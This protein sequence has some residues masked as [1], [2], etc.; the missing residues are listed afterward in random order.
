VLNILI[1]GSKFAKFINTLTNTNIQLAE[2]TL[3]QR[4]E[5]FQFQQS[6][7]DLFQCLHVI[8]TPYKGSN[9]CCDGIRPCLQPTLHSQPSPSYCT[10]QKPC[11]EKAK[12]TIPNKHERKDV[13]HCS[14]EL[15]ALLYTSWPVLEF[16]TSASYGDEYEDG[17][18]LERHTIYSGTYQPTPEIT[19][20]R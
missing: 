4:D 14:K 13:L 6:G 12:A 5:G 8:L 1:C 11:N 19:A 2:L 16:E 20:I 7:P 3:H 18:L 9:V 17:C 10:S 15:S